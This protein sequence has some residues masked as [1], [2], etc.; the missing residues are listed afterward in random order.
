MSFASIP[1][2]YGLQGLRDGLACLG[3]NRHRVGVLGE[4]VERVKYVTVPVVV[5]GP[6]PHVHQ[7]LLPQVANDI[8]RETI[9]DK[10]LQRS[11]C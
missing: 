9:T 11:P 3:A 8:H 4:G 7:A 2:Q 1:G 10:P 5:L 6:K